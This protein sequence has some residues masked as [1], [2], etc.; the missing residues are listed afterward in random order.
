MAAETSGPIAIPAMQIS[1][2]NTQV[3]TPANIP[4]PII[5]LELN[6]IAY[7]HE[8]P[9]PLHLIRSSL[10]VCGD[11]TL[12]C[13]QH[14]L[15]PFIEPWRRNAEIGESTE[16]GAA[17]AKILVGIYVGAECLTKK[18]LS[19]LPS[20]GGAHRPP[21][22]SYCGVGSSSSDHAAVIIWCPGRI[23][24]LSAVSYHAELNVVRPTA[25]IR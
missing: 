17:I 9:V 22:F 16:R 7:P 11:I 14:R 13:L 5:V 2:I 19:D 4:T 20:G 8:T 6:A 24:V 15:K 12:G 21:I 23:I 3:A 18:E 1:G 10:M 25:P